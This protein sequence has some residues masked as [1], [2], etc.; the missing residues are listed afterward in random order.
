MLANNEHNT[1]IDYADHTMNEMKAIDCPVAN[2]G[3]GLEEFCVHRE[4]GE[5]V[6]V[7]LLRHVRKIAGRAPALQRTLTEYPGQYG[8]LAGLTSPV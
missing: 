8:L 6:P 1:S 3:C 4:K 7:L 5:D 2:T